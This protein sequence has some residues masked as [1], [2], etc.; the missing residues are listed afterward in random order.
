MSL[1]KRFPSR[2]WLP[3]LYACLRTRSPPLPPYTAGQVSGD[4]DGDGGGVPIGQLMM[5]SFGGGQQPVRRNSMEKTRDRERKICFS[6]EGVAFREPWWWL[7]CVFLDR[8]PIDQ[9][10]S[11]SIACGRQSLTQFYIKHHSRKPTLT[12]RT[13]PSDQICQYEQAFHTISATA[14]PWHSNVNKLNVTS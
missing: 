6:S 10:E 8:C 12:T 5:T 2:G 9:C 1:P 4:G 7:T 3:P 14:L 11:W 13:F